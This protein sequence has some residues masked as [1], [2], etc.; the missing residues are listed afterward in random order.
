[1]ATAAFTIIW[2]FIVPPTRQAEFESR[3]GPDGDW[4]RLFRR[5]AGYLGSELLR[6][7]ADPQ[8][9]LTVDRWENLEAWRAF[10]SRFAADYDQLDRQFE[11]LAEHEA[12]LGEYGP[13]GEPT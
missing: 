2:E 9:Y 8:R 11:G 12:P 4:V 3:Y 6:D 1:M 10:R 13:A 7:R 5:G